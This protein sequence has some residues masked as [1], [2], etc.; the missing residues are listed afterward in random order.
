VSR[1]NNL[2]RM[3]GIVI[4]VSIFLS[5]YCLGKACFNIETIYDGPI[6]KTIFWNIS[7]FSFDSDIPSEYNIIRSYDFTTKEVKEFG[8]RGPLI[9]D[10]IPERVVYVD[11]IGTDVYVWQM[12][13]EGNSDLVMSIG[14]VIDRISPKAYLK[15]RFYYVIDDISYE[16]QGKLVCEDKIGN[17]YYYNCPLAIDGCIS[18]EGLV[19]W[20]VNSNNLFTDDISGIGN[21]IAIEDPKTG[22]VS[23]IT[24]KD[25]KERERIVFCPSWYN[26]EV[27]LF[28]V[29]SPQ[30]PDWTWELRWLNTL[31]GEYGVVLTENGPITDCLMEGISLDESKTM[32]AYRYKEPSEDD[33]HGIPRVIDMISGS[34][35]DLPNL[36]HED[37]YREVCTYGN[38]IIWFE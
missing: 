26:S 14:G 3:I 31:T 34:S 13:A 35:L 9:Y 17:K 15:G 7:R 22:S 5:Q 18:S 25:L 2:Q 10:D 16:T 30:N 12:D 19:A 8:I 36:I 28:C 4:I 32:I 37:E 24:I 38:R 33:F 20:P 6:E 27:V 21:A 11:S 1:T 23:V 29:E